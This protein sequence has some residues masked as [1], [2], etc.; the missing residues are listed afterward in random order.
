[1]AQ[2]FYH[3]PH[4]GVVATVIYHTTCHT[5]VL[6]LVFALVFSTVLIPVDVSRSIV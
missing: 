2:I 6:A 1:M 3:I 4:M 5:F